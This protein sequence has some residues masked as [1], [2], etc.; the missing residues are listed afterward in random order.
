VA[1]GLTQSTRYYN[2]GNA[3]TGTQT[4]AQLRPAVHANDAVVITAYNGA[5]QA[6]QVTTNPSGTVTR[7]TYDN[8]GNLVQTDRAWNTSEVRTDRARYDAEW[9]TRG[10]N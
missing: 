2:R 9:A 8:V 3:Y 1:G 7:Y 4:V 10:K 6:T 5:N